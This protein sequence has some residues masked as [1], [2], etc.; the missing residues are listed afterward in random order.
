VPNR[1][2]LTDIALRALKPTTTQTTYWDD[3]V[4]AF[5]VRVGRRSKTFLI[6]RDGGHRIRIGRYPVMSLHEARKEAKRLLSLAELPRAVSVTVSQAV[7]T[8]L[9]SR[10]QQNRSNTKQET[11]RLLTR[12]LLP[13]LGDRLLADV[14]TEH[15]IPILDGLIKKTGTANH[16]CT[17]MKTF[18][19]WAVARRHIKHSPLA[20]VPLPAK[21]GKRDRVLTDAELVAVYRAAQGMGY[22]F[23]FII[24]ICIHTGM[25]R[26][27]VGS[28]KWSYI[29]PDCI[30]LPADA[31]KNAQQ[32]VIPNLIQG[33]LKLIPKTS[34]FLF[35]NETGAPFT[36]WNTSKKK[37]DERC[38]VT[39]WV[40]HDLRRTFSTKMAEW[41]LA[42]PHVIER[43]LNHASGTMSPL[44]RIYNRAT[45]LAEMRQALT[46]YEQRLAILIS[47]A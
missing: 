10:Q 32:H 26:G 15:V 35:P 37:I 31:T 14:A 2:H 42:P 24:L 34:E 7:A 28:L 44:S 40:I 43:L 5:G 23:G 16:A 4:P 33:N 47:S 19:N 30:T 27:E 1:I 17:A 22:P 45:Y 25:R 12:H 36:D 13:T 29:T 3:A 8:F 18:F 39:G 46:A 9:E 20:G 6:V 38:G 11:E 21:A 41:Q